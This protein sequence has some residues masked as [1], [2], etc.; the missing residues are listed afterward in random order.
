MRLGLLILVRC[1]R[2]ALC[3]DTMRLVAARRSKEDEPV[4]FWPW[5]VGISCKNNVG[6]LIEEVV[7]INTT[8]LNNISKPIVTLLCAFISE[9]FYLFSNFED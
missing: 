2:A 5:A 1:R 9:S 6:I 8:F 3:A 7:N 4:T